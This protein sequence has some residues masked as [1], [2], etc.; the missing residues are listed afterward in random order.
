MRWF[1]IDVIDPNSQ[2]KVRSSGGV[3][4]GLRDGRLQFV[5]DVP[6]GRACGC[7]CPDPTC[8]QPLIA[9]NR[10]SIDRRRAYHFTHVSESTSCS[11]RESAIHRMAKQLLLDAKSIALPAWIS[12]A[13]VEIRP[14]T[15]SL[16]GTPRAEVTLLDGRLRPDIRI[17]P[18]SDGWANTPLYV[19]IRVTHPVD[20]LKSSLIREGRFNVIEIDL[21]DATDDAVVDEQEF[22]RLVLESD[23]NRSWIHLDAASYLSTE[24]GQFIYDVRHAVDEPFAV[25]I[26]G[27][28]SIL[29]R[30]QSVHR[31]DPDGTVHAMHIE[32]EQCVFDGQRIADC[33]GTSLPYAPGLY[34][35]GVIDSS[36]WSKSSWFKTRLTPLAMRASARQFQLF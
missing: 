31:H 25:E 2:W 3:P 36:R 5:S 20:A 35:Q 23:R 11:G 12:T 33:Q 29:V 6:T 8:A 13:D 4:F 32:L 9:K 16:A 28:G 18:Q 24:L 17:E 10:P 27:G 1:A 34:L 15:V 19:E 21:S 30:R 26:S 22:R 7:V 14:K